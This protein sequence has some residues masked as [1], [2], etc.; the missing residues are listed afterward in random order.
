MHTLILKKDNYCHLAFQSSQLLHG[1]VYKT[2]SIHSW[3]LQQQSTI[4]FFSLCHSLGG[5][6][7]FLLWTSTIQ[8]EV[9]CG[10]VNST[11]SEES[12][13]FVFHSSL[14]WSSLTLRIVSLILRVM[15][16]N[17]CLTEF[18]CQRAFKNVSVHT[19]VGKTRLFV[20]WLACSVLRSLCPL[21]SCLRKASVTELLNYLATLLWYNSQ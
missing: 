6:L 18:Q 2:S 21:S 17:S 20:W 5:Q 16:V 7:F 14:K 13:L 1:A 4:L 11:P 8:P 9:A 12:A 10:M 19:H 15:T 3:A